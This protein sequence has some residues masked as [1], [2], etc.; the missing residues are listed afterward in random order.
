MK[1]SELLN[2]I[3]SWLENSENEAIL[4]A[5]HNDDCLKVVAESCVQAAT[6]LR[7]AADHT[8]TLEE[9][10]E[11]NITPENVEKL[12]SIASA[13]DSSGDEDLIKQASL[14]DE[15]LLTISSSKDAVR[16]KRAADN[17]KIELLKKKYND[18]K[19]KQDELNKKPEMEKALNNS[20]YLKEYRPMQFGLQTRYCPDHPGVMLQRISDHKGQ[21]PLDKKVYDFQ[22][23]FSLINGTKVPGTS[24]EEQSKMD[25]IDH[26]S[27]FSTRENR[28]AK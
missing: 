1:T 22:S 4:L 21:C 12:A 26:T 18:S 14:I 10:E 15:L 16:A 27:D 8:D 5:E 11:S 19:T 25:V 28:L 17:E 3:A 6:I 7:L 24:V 13:F 23:G 2:A 20:E 9:D